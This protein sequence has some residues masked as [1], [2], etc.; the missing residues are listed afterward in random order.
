MFAIFFCFSLRTL[1]NYNLFKITFYLPAALPESA[2]SLTSLQQGHKE[3]VRY[4]FSKISIPV[5]LNHLIRIRCVD[6]FPEM[7]EV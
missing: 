3:L 1:K 7:F 5:F 2:S 6:L 4:P